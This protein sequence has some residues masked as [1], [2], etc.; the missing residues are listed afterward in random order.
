MKKAIQI[1]IVDDYAVVREG[2]R[3]FIT[4]ESDMEVV[5]EAADGETAVHLCQTLNPDVVIMDLALPNNEGTEAIQTIRQSF[6]QVY[7]LVLTNFAE[8]DRVM[9]AL[10]SG[11]HGYMLKDATTQDILRAVRNV[12]RGKTVLHPSVA[13]VL[14]RALQASNETKQTLLEGLTKR[15]RD[16]LQL[17][18]QGHTNQEIAINLKIDARTVRVHVSHVLQKLNLNNR[19]Q[20]AL[21]AL[22]HGLATL[23]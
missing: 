4:T 16:V 17:I 6:P 9:A 3:A 20:A 15:E 19:T 1:L 5:G 21:F 12:Y 13:Y 14:L 8:E 10:K 2:L 22:R 7:I 18:A 11:A 23:K